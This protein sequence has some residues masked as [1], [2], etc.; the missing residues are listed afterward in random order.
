MVDILWCLQLN[1]G[2]EIYLT[3]VFLL[4]KFN[5]QIELAE[6]HAKEKHMRNITLKKALVAVNFYL[7]VQDFTKMNNFI[8]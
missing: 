8:S 5:S 2:K 3:C 6:S 1:T 4:Q 7:I